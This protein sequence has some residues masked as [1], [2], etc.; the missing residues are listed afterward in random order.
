MKINK[1]EQ[2]IFEK[3]QEYGKNAKLAGMSRDK[4][5]EGLR[6][7][8][9]IKDM[10][11]IKAVVE[12]KGIWA[13]RPV[14]RVATVENQKIWAEKAMTMSKNTLEVYVRDMVE[15]EKRSKINNNRYTNE[16]KSH[17]PRTAKNDRK[18]V[19]K[20][21]FFQKNEN[22][23]T[24]VSMNLKSETAEKLQ[25]VKGKDDWESLMEEFIKFKEEKEKQ[26]QKE[27]KKQK[28][29]AIKSTSHYVPAAIQNYVRRRAKHKC[30]SPGCTK[31]GKH[32]HHT[33]PFALKKEH[34]PDKIRLLCEQ[35]HDIAHH[36]LVENEE[37][38]PQ[39]WK[40][41]KFPNIYD[42]KNLI[43]NRIADFKKH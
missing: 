32:L 6:I 14:V 38:Q 7:L 43:N 19:D 39:K 33:T 29:K 31:E 40:P 41:L 30:E 34:D 10:P 28:P 20:P 27:L 25:K 37:M 9:K 35:H 13:A 16:D 8:D 15:E 26:F 21:N 24:T 11:E 23:K 1:K 42:L 5:N 4:V 18:A 2:A 22:K 36:G 17:R 12:K 3:F